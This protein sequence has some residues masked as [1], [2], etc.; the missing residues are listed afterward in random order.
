MSET[1]IQFTCYRFIG[2]SGS[3]EGKISLLS[4]VSRCIWGEKEKWSLLVTLYSL[5]FTEYV[6]N[7]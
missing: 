2:F 3:N 7:I 1:G 4:M 5:N 6:S